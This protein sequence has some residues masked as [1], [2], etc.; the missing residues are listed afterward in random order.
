MKID[1]DRNVLVLAVLHLGLGYMPAKERSRW[2]DLVLKIKR[3]R[4]LSLAQAMKAAK[5][6]YRK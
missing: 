2:L 1:Q 5:L 4:G 6:V 3:E